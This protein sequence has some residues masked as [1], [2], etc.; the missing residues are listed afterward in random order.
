[1]RRIFLKRRIN[2]LSRRYYRRISKIQL[3][4]DCFTNDEKFRLIAF[5]EEYKVLWDK[6]TKQNK[7]T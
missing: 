5:T 2:R 4:I 7:E 6:F 3:E 1:M